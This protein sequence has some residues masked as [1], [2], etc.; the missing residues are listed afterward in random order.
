M[1]DESLAGGS[2]EAMDASVEAVETT[3]ENLAVASAEDIIRA[4]RDH[5]ALVENV[6]KAKA[7]VAQISGHLDGAKEALAN[8][9]AELAAAEGN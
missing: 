1:T 9:E 2:G 8:A 5:Q 4:E 3:E 7:R 6:E